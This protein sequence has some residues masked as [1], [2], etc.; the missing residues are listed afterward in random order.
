M[1]TSASTTSE[2]TTAPTT[3]ALDPMEA[4][5]R[6]AAQAVDR[7][8]DDHAEKILS[9]I[10]EGNEKGTAQKTAADSGRK[11]DTEL[12]S[13]PD[14]KPK[15]EGKDGKKADKKDESQETPYTKAKKENERFDRNWK[16]FQEEQAAF[17]QQVAQKERELAERE[18]RITGTPSE[19][20]AK[21]NHGY[22]AS[23]WD[24][25][26]AAWEKEGKYDLADAAKESAKNLR[27]QERR[28]QAS[29]S[30]GARA[31]VGKPEETPGTQQFLD[32]W[33]RN[34]VHLM[35]TPEFADLG[36][37]DSELFKATAEILNADP[38]FK[39][40]NDGIRYAAELA[41]AKLEASSVPGLR[42]Q[43]EQQTKELEKLRKATS[44]SGSSNAEERGGS[45][46]FEEMTPAEQ[47]TFLAKASR[48]ADANG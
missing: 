43:I 42:Q 6:Q 45:K 30:A 35:G 1:S 44:P 34:L 7:G 15:E 23:D 8:D 26:A 41:R 13:E 25:A 22:T 47:E 29:A 2:T 33:N 24:K 28:G 16:K 48:E 31:P 14:D 17:K 37:K 39:K 10:P 12:P 11:T 20:P 18:Q 27:E 3:P 9:E 38:R 19:G 36:K 32:T 4:S 40:Y 5:L 21:D 46:S